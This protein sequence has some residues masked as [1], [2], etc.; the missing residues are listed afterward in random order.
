MSIKQQAINIIAME[1][2]HMDNYS[3]IKELNTLAVQF[4]RL[5]CFM[6]LYEF[7]NI[8]KLVPI[9]KYLKERLV[10]HRIKEAVEQ[11]IKLEQR[12]VMEHIMVR[13]IKEQECKI[14][15]IV[16]EQ[17]LHRIGLAVEILLGIEQVKQEF[18]NMVHFE[19]YMLFGQLEQYINSVK[20]NIKVSELDVEVEKSIEEI[21]FTEEVEY[22]IEYTMF[23]E[24][25]IVAI[26]ASKNAVKIVL[27]A[28]ADIEINRVVVLAMNV[29]GAADRNSKFHQAVV[30]ELPA[31]FDS[32]TGL[33]IGT[34]MLAQKLMG[35]LV[36]VLVFPF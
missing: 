22:S 16:A 6:E 36:F 12:F 29:V 25:C 34:V 20:L 8:I 1:F 13:V 30:S 11:D 33:Q 17:G 2:K 21:K 18:D 5:E 3:Q 15:V 23:R 35:S 7:K 27:S 24:A 32:G 10:L 26:E 28:M 4:D 31:S 9:I 14:A 19:E